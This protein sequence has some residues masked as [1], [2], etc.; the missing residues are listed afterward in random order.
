MG[1]IVIIPENMFGNCDNIASLT[2]N[3]ATTTYSIQLVLIV[4]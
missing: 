2:L 4:L 1:A 3:N